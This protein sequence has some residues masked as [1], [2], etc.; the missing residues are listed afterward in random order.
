LFKWKITTQGGENQQL[1]QF[2]AYEE[3]AS[4]SW[5]LF[6]SRHNVASQK[7]CIFNTITVRTS[8]TT[9][10]MSASENFFFLGNRLITTPELATS[11]NYLAVNLAF[12][13]FHNTTQSNIQLNNNIW[14]CTLSLEKKKYC[15]T[16][17]WCLSYILRFCKHF[18]IFKMLC[19]TEII[20]ER[21]VTYISTINYIGVCLG[22]T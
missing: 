10:N 13:D 18:V 14:E 4:R 16:I 17:W 1:H 7:I 19:K 12:Q 20:F 11:A 3:D 5:Q 21:K 15:L 9:S 22:S 6:S 2:Q 8:N